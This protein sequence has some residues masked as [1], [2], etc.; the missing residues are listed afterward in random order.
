MP[1]DLRLGLIDSEGHGQQMFNRYAYDF[2]EGLHRQY[3]NVARIY[4]I[5][6][7][8]NDLFRVSPWVT[9]MA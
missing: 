6:G 4:G 5:F 2:H 8:G 1:R 7:V 9:L 3:G